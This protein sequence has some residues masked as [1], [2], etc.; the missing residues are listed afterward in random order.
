[1]AIISKL[2]QGAVGKYL[3]TMTK[4]L[5]CCTSRTLDTVTRHCT[6]HQTHECKHVSSWGWNDDDRGLSVTM[7]YYM[8]HKPWPQVTSV[9]T[10]DQWILGHHQVAPVPRGVRSL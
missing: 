4:Y 2:V 6:G 5:R 7:S 1:M 10:S 8:S 9:V 3:K